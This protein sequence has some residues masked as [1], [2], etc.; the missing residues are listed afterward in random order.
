MKGLHVCLAALGGMAVGAA[1]ALLYAPQKG[2]K[3]RHEIIKFL[4]DHCPMVKESEM[5]QIA[6]AIEEKVEA[7]KKKGK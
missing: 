5:E 4:K 7:A 1:V 3:T 6:D 2:R